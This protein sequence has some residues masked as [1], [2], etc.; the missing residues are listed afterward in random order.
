MGCLIE[1]KFCEDSRNSISN[2][3]WKFQLSIL[4]NKKVLSLK[5]HFC[6]RCQYQNK[7]ALFTDPIFSEGF[8][9]ARLFLL[10]LQ[11][12]HDSQLTVSETELYTYIPKGLLSFVRRRE[13]SIGLDF[14]QPFL[15]VF[16]CLDW[17]TFDVKKSRLGF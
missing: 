11:F 4:K 10:L 5:K 12:H 9:L 14:S 2:R 6:G 7:T 15:Q 3:C 13:F 1:L 17:L 8:G 16:L